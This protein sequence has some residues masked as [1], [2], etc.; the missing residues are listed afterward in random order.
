MHG[1]HR[2]VRYNNACTSDLDFIFGQL[3]GS[4]REH[5]VEALVFPF[6]MDFT[7]DLWDEIL[8]RGHRF[9]KR[10]RIWNRVANIYGL[11]DLANVASEVLLR[12]CGEGW[13]PCVLSD[14]CVCEITNRDRDRT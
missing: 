10:L 8:H 7:E 12:C 4:L 14:S 1:N 13:S 2:L 11:E 9:T 6:G 5:G 3:G